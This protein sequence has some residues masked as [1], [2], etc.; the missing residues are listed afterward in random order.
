MRQSIFEIHLDELGKYRFRVRSSDNKIIAIG[1]G[2]NTRE[3]CIKGIMDVKQS[4]E[5]YI[6]S[7]IKDFTK[8]ETILILNRSLHR[9]RIGSTITFSGRLF[10]NVTGEGLENAKIGIYESDGAFLKETPLA[11]GNTS[12][13]GGFNID[14][15][16]KKMDWWDNSIEI[17]AKF[18]GEERLRAS[19]SQKLFFHLIK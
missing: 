6:N 17:Y 7:D 5:K 15:T 4:N 11:S 9:V 14:W 12:I 10:G 13:L 19:S 8:G 18:E 1:D 16:V 3:S 2:C